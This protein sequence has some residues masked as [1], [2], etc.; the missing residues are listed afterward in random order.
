MY[1][2]LNIQCKIIVYCLQIGLI[3]TYT[4]CLIEVTH[5]N[6]VLACTHT[7]IFRNFTPFSFMASISCPNFKVI[8]NQWLQAR[9]S[10][11]ESSCS[12]FI[13]CYCAIVFL[14][15][16]SALRLNITMA[17]GC[18]NWPEANVVFGYI[19]STFDIIRFAPVQS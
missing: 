5:S 13:H 8:L 17:N 15:T 3:P 19:T 18:L 12:G 9:L 14:G 16:T 7:N 2:D 1:S 11:K 4:R 10:C 6:L